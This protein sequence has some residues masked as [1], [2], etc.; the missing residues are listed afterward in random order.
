MIQR[1]YILRMIEEFRREVEVVMTNRSESR[2][3]EVVGTVDEQF[4]QLI[5]V[6]V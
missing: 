1:D 4:R 3:Q 6:L 5:G 2:W